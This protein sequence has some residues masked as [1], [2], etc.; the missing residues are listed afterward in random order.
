MKV[1]PYEVIRCYVNVTILNWELYEKNMT[2][3]IQWVSLIR[4]ILWS[5]FLVF[6]TGYSIYFTAINEADF[7]ELYILNSYF[8]I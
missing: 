5:A 1:F 7:T 2:K 8:V 3:N 6:I 4:N